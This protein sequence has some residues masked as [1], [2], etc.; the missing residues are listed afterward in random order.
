MSNTDNEIE[1]SI[2]ICYPLCSELFE[3]F[4]CSLWSKWNYFKYLECSQIFSVE[5][6]IFYCSPAELDGI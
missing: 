4:S 3:F 5:F 2:L 6:M 1:K